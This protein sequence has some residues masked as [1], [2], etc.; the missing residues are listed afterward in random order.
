MGWHVK[1]RIIAKAFFRKLRS[2]YAL[3]RYPDDQRHRISRMS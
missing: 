2:E 3:P 1:Q